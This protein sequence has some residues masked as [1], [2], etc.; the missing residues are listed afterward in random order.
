MQCNARFKI[1]NVQPKNV[2][3][4]LTAHDDGVGCT[5]TAGGRDHN[6][7][8]TRGTRYARLGRAQTKARH[9]TETPLPPAGRR[10]TQQRGE[11]RRGGVARES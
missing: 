1:H 5:P 3:Y 6:E 2:R 8:Q 10:A 9:S 4:K 11:P 7:K